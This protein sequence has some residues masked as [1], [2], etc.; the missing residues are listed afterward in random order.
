MLPDPTRPGFN[1]GCLIAL[2]INATVLIGVALIA[3]Q[4][5]R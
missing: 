2:I 5:W 4:L 1:W 3:V